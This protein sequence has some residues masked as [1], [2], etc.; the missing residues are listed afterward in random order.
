MVLILSILIAA[1]SK[2]L[3][4]TKEDLYSKSL[5]VDPTTQLVL[6]SKMNEGVTC[7]EYPQGCHAAHIV[8][9]KGL[10]LIAV[11]FD[12]EQNAREAAKK[13]KGYYTRNWLLDDVT[14]EP[15]LERFVVD[16]L[17]AKKP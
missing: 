4:W 6:P 11:E 7:D 1:C 17:E 12:N 10:E 13:L 14:K 16:H 15:V 2:E 5:Q 9:I 8:R 3:K